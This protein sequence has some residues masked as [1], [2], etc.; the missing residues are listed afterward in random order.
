[1]ANYFLDTNVLVGHCY[2][3]NRWQ[4]HTRRLFSTDNTLHTSELVLY[5]YC[6]KS[7][8]GAPAPSE[9][10]GW[11]STNGVFGRVRRKLRKGKRHSELELRRYD[12]EDLTPA[13]V[14][15]VFI[16]KFEIEDEVAGIV[17]AH[18]QAVLDDDCDAK[19]AREEIDE[20]V[21]SITT[22]AADR[23]AKLAR[24]V[25]FHRRSRSHESVEDQLVRLIY[26]EN[27]DY[28]PDAGVLAD[29]YDL[30]SRGLL[31][32]VVTGDKGDMYLNAEDINSITGLTVMYL[33]DE[34]ADAAV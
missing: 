4:S 11:G 3:H 15:E 19:D 27:T 30:R 22:T 34:F 1:M 32:K 12:K 31:S 14:A 20:L 28:G 33:K 23:K 21:N 6:V 25:D 16:D 24:R 17:E 8:P 10:I 13:K 29:A 2:L 26:D 18:F 7:S 9:D 5:E